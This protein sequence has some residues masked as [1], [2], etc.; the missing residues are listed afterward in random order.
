M[1]P[2]NYQPIAIT[3]FIDLYNTLLEEISL[4]Y[5]TA[6]SKHPF[7]FFQKCMS[8]KKKSQSG[9]R[10]QKDGVVRGNIRGRKTNTQE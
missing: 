1:V 6:R 3:N 2:D 7:S 5:L 4:Q 8:A 10:I 9:N